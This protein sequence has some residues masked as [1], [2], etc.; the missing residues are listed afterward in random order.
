MVTSLDPLPPEKVCVVLPYDDVVPHSNHPVVDAPFGLT[1]PLSVAEEE[2][3]DVAALVVTVG[4]VTAVA[5][6]VKDISSPYLVPALFWPTARK[7]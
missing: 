7:W 4:F 6:V 1:L 2:A 3:T 5:D